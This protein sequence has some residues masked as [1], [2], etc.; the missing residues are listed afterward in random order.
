MREDRK[1]RL[2]WLDRRLSEGALV[3][4]EIYMREFNVSE[5]LEMISKS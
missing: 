4:S 2:K 3:T 1:A 5:H